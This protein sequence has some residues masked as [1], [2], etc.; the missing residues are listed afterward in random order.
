M[1]VPGKGYVGNN[2][3]MWLSTTIFYRVESSPP[4]KNGRRV[5][6][7]IFRCIF[8]NEIICILIDISLK[9]VPKGPIWWLPSIG[10]DN[11]LV[12]NK[13]QAIMWT[14]ADPIHWR[15]YAALGGMG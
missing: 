10:L 2:P 9:F 12:P 6:N 7:N 3:T 5:A 15:I 13:R 1:L 11:G 4:G 14:N 8:V